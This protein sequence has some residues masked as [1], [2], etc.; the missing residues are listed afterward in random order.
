MT[1]PDIQS[2]IQLQFELEQFYYEEAAMLDERRYS[3][4]LE[5]LA[6]DIHYW[7]PIRRTRTADELDKEFTAPGAMAF[8][9][10]DKALLEARV[11]K[12]ESGY[13]WSEDPPSRTRHFVSNVRV[14]AIDGDEI[15]VEANAHL[16]RSRLDSEEDTWIG[17]RR[18]VLRRVND[19]FRI[20]KRHIFLDQTIILSRNLS[21][22]F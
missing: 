10:D 12:L 11:R 22:F 5:L 8:F 3:D 7:M 1:T 19:S 6:D 16:Y 17:L 15:T 20:T 18:D 2:R 14:T 13:A 21:S 9:D 4:W